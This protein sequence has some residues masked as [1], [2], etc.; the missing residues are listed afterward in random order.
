MRS[1]RRVSKAG[2]SRQQG[3]WTASS[4]VKDDFGVSTTCPADNFHGNTPHCCSSLV[5]RPTKT[6]VAAVAALPQAA[7]STNMMLGGLRLQRARIAEFHFANSKLQQ[8]DETCF[9]ETSFSAPIFG[10]G[11]FESSLLQVSNFLLLTWFNQSLP[12]DSQPFV[13]LFVREEYRP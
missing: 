11:T 5:S 9:D 3:T 12:T 10:A 2:D 6:G 4:D 7:A 8:N 13:S 1:Q